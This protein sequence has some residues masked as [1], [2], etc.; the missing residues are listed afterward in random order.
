MSV[1]PFSPINSVQALRPAEPL[2]LLRTTGPKGA[3][4]VVTRGPSPPT[5]ESARQEDDFE[6][7]LR[8][9]RRNN[10]PELATYQ[11]LEDPRQIIRQMYRSGRLRSRNVGFNNEWEQEQSPLV[12]G[13]IRD[14]RDERVGDTRRLGEEQAQDP[15]RRYILLLEARERLDSR[16]SN[17]LNDALAQQLDE[18][19]EYNWDENSKVILAGFNTAPTLIED[20]KN[21]EVWHYF[22]SIYTGFVLHE[23]TLAATYKALLRKFKSDGVSHAVLMLRNAIAADL[24]SP[25]VSGNAVQLQQYYHDLEGN[26]TIHSIMQ[27]SDTLCK[28][29]QGE[30]TTSDE[31][32]RFV[33]GVFDFVGSAPNSAIGPEH[34]L[35]TLCGLLRAR[36]TL[37]ADAVREQ[38]RMFLKAKIP[39]GLWHSQ[40]MHDSLYPVAFRARP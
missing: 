4:E 39:Y 13:L 2:A 38:V 5:T 9:S 12:E 10:T 36:Q 25:Y 22:R 31:V 37:N 16:R 26:R 11:R 30:S 29:V 14:L 33:E 21:V 20:A 3:G 23:A 19:L 27:E 28:K 17:D 32:M 34:R 18:A 35:N 7:S 1:L 24:R 40:L 6:V 8:G 15:F